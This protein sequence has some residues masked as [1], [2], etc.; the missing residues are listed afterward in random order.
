MT[1]D[2]ARAQKPAAQRVVFVTQAGLVA[3]PFLCPLVA[4]PSVQAW[5]LL[6]TWVCLAA[7]L[8]AVPAAVPARGIWA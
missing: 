1:A 7:M 8:L 4:G 5:Q 3:F 2:I 6:A